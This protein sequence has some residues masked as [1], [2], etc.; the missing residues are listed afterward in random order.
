[1]GPLRIVFRN[2]HARYS[3][4]HFEL[5][6]HDNLRVTRGAPTAR[7]T[8]ARFSLRFLASKIRTGEPTTPRTGPI[9]LGAPSADLRMPR[10]GF[11]K[12]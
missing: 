2:L 9:A 6:C 1:M 10:Y 11:V 8:R 12:A 3:L 7:G 5:L 4:R